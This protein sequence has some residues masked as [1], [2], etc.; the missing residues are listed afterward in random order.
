MG[1]LWL[2]QI[3]QTGPFENSAINWTIPYFTLSLSLNVLVTIAIVLRLLSYRHRIT[4]VLG[5]SH[6]SQYTSIAAMIV[7]SAAIFSAFSIC[8]LVPF[9]LSSSISSIFLQALGQ[10]QI[11]ATLLII[12]RVASGKGW[13]SNTYRSTFDD[14]SPEFQMNKISRVQFHTERS[15]E[16]GE[17]SLTAFDKVFVPEGGPAETKDSSRALQSF[18][19]AKDEESYVVDE[20]ISPVPGIGR[21]ALSDTDRYYESSLSSGPPLRYRHDGPHSPV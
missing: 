18:G 9:A 6:G 1:V 20:P 12:Y 2:I 17:T 8:F 4:N 13:S 11:S 14:T 3:S 7:E 10:V 15:G 5:S 16:T 21:D 19:S